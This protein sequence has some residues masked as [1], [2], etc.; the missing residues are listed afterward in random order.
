MKAKTSVSHD[1]V[2]VERLRKNRAFAVEYLRAALGVS[3][4]A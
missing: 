2:I 4:A 3:T 1:E